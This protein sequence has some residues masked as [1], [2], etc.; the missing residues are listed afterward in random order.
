MIEGMLILISILLAVVLFLLFLLL[1]RKDNKD[2]LKVDHL[3][4]LE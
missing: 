1:T 2:M 3:S 4:A